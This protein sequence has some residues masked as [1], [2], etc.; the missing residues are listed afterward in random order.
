MPRNSYKRERYALCFVVHSLVCIIGFIH[1]DALDVVEEVIRIIYFHLIDQFILYF[2]E[3][4]ALCSVLQAYF[5]SFLSYVNYE[6]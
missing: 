6:D 2:T 3:S 5:Y 4:M 1:L